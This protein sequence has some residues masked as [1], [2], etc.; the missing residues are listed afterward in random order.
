M[1][2]SLL[3]VLLPPII[4]IVSKYLIDKVKNMKKAPIVEPEKPLKDGNN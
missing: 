4:E 2:K 1:L 3:K